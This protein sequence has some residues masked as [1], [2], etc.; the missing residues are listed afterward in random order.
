MDLRR[1]ETQ[2]ESLIGKSVNTNLQQ[3]SYETSPPAE[4]LRDAGVV[5]DTA[6]AQH[7]ITLISNDEPLA[8]IDFIISQQDPVAYI[9]NIEIAERVQNNGIGSSLRSNVV[10]NLSQRV[11]RI[12][13]YPTNEQ[14][15]HIAV[16]QDF[17]PVADSEVLSGWYVKYC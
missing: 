16:Q 9:Q 3:Y 15:T 8:R 7:R 2:L 5:S 1:V 17:E 6:V 11:D 14:I 13:S 4:D 10:S 12:Y